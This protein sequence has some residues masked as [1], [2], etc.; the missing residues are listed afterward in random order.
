MNSRQSGL[1]S[2]FFLFSLCSTSTFSS[3]LPENMIDPVDGKFD[4]SNY[5]ASAKV[6]LSVPIII[7]E[8]AVGLGVAAS[9]FH[10]PKELDPE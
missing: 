9:Y 3:W 6:F 2:F 8:P 10:A 4:A 7:T 1:F 5:L